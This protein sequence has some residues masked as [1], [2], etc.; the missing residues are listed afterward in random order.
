MYTQVIICGVT[1]SI[2]WAKLAYTILVD[3]LPTVNDESD[4]SWDTSID[5]LFQLRKWIDTK[6]DHGCMLLSFCCIVHPPCMSKLE[7]SYFR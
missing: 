1:N 6:I 5:L 4:D 2:G 7:S 3:N